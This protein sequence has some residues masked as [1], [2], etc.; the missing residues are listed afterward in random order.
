MGVQSHLSY[1]KNS[2]IYLIHKFWMQIS[3]ILTNIC[4]SNIPQKVSFFVISPSISAPGNYLSDSFHNRLTEWEFHTNEIILY[5]SFCV[6]LLLHILMSWHSSILLYEL[7]VCFFFI[8]G[9]YSIW[10]TF[11][12]LPLLCHFGLFPV[13]SY[14]EHIKLHEQ[15]IVWTSIFVPPG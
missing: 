1:E 11:L 4:I 2:A 12:H 15:I 6:W 9:Y 14:N 7:A 13:S 3:M 8:A 10:W 5:R